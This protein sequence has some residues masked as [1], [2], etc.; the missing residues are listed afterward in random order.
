MLLD[1]LH[2]PN[3]HHEVVFIIG[4]ADEH[5]LKRTD[6]QSYTCDCGCELTPERLDEGDRMKTSWPSC[7]SWR[8]GGNKRCP[9]CNSKFH[10]PPR[11]QMG[12]TFGYETRPK[13]DYSD[14]ATDA[15]KRRAREEYGKSCLLCNSEDDLGYVKIVSHKFYGV[16]DPPNLVPFCADH[17]PKHHV[18]LDISYP[19]K[20]MRFRNLVN[21]ESYVSDLREQY[22]EAG[23]E[24]TEFVNHL[25]TLIEH[26]PVPP[27]DPYW[28]AKNLDRPTDS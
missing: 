2:N 27:R 23:H 14:S 24:G 26:G 3:G 7:K 18:F 10:M 9:E 11:E 25:D 15:R 21:W 12:R 1:A 20:W 28:Q 6:V 17:K 5:G 22:V 19:G 8:D 16:A 13:D 4:Q